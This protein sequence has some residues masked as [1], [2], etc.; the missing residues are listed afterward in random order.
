MRSLTS[1]RDSVLSVTREPSSRRISAARRRACGIVGWPGKTAR[2]WRALWPGWRLRRPKSGPFRAE[3]GSP[4][5]ALGRRGATSQGRGRG[6]RRCPRVAN[7]VC[8][9]GGSIVVQRSPCF[10]NETFRRDVRPM[11]LRRRQSVH[12]PC[13]AQIGLDAFGRARHPVAKAA[14]IGA[15]CGA[16][17]EQYPPVSGLIGDRHIGIHFFSHVI[18]PVRRAGARSPARDRGVP[19][20]CLAQLLRDVR[21]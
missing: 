5:G 1:I 13:R 6:C 15:R 3:A 21:V 9:R 4:S 20:D 14:M 7:D 16:T 12:Q 11:H 8:V 19:G 17:L 10:A 2:R 18:L